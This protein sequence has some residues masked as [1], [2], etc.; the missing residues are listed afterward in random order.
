[1]ENENMDEA[2]LGNVHMGHNL[3]KF[4]QLKGIKQT[5]LGEMVGMNHQQAISRLENQ[6]VISVKTLEKIAPILGVS[7]EV[8]RTMPDDNSSVIIE[9]NTFQRGSSNVSFG[10]SNIYNEPIDKAMKFFKQHLDEERKQKQ[11]LMDRIK[12]LE[13]MIRN[14]KK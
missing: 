7:V 12:E 14:N 8:L 3:R 1:M 2:L 10:D 13:E 9:N 4:R 6:K 5:V 11:E